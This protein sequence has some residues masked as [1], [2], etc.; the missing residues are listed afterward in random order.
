MRTRTVQ[1][2]NAFTLVELLVVI[3]IILILMALTV[4]VLSRVWAYWD[5][6]R[7][8]VEINKLAESCQIF[9]STF[10]RYPPAKIM[11][12]ENGATYAAIISSGATSQAYKNLAAYS[13]E[14]LT[15]IFPGIS[16]A[17]QGNPSGHDWSGR[18]GGGIK[19]NVP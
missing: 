15:S 18:A 2:R 19:I 3:A 11:L 9:K 7:T 13:V 10:G 12:C 5:E 8:S 17:P 4:G 16:L 6:T 1:K 14:Y